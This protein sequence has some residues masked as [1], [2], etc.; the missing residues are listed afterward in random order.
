MEV[1]TGQNGVSLSYVTEYLVTSVDEMNAIDTTKCAPGSTCIV[2]EGSGNTTVYILT[3]I[4]KKTVE[5]R[6]L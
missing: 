1:I 3:L 2:A 4:D 6:Q 5:W